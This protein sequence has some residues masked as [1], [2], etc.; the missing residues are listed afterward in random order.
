[1][2]AEN[3]VLAVFFLLTVAGNVNAA[4]FDCEKATSQV[5]KII[6]GDE[7]LSILDEALNV[8]YLKALKRADIQQQTVASQRQWLKKERNACRDAASLK[9][10]YETRIQALS[11]LSSHRDYSR[12]DEDITRSL[13]VTCDYSDYKTVQSQSVSIE[14]TEENKGR[15]AGVKKFKRR[16]DRDEHEKFIVRPG[17]FC[18]CIYPSGTRVRVKVGEGSS[19]PFGECGA[20]PEVFMSLWV[21]ERKIASKVWFAGHCIESPPRSAQYPAVSFKISGGPEGVSVQKCHTARQGESDLTPEDAEVK[22]GAVERLSVC[23]DYSDISKYPKDLVEYPPK[24]TETPKVGDIEMLYGSGAVCEAVLEGLKRHFDDF[25]EQNDRD[26]STTK[27]SSPNWSETSFQLHEEANGCYESVFD[28]NNDGKLDRVFSCRFL[29]HYRQG[30]TLLVQLGRSST[31]LMVDKVRHNIREFSPFSQENYEAGFSMKGR[32]EKDK[33]YFTGRY[34]DFSP[35]FF[36]GT[37]YIAVSSYSEDTKDYVAVLKPLPDGT[38]Q[39]IGLFRRVPE[40]F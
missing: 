36:Q 32:N 12:E 26:Q 8:A 27:L 15:P 10:A 30:S 6:C 28:L 22:K 2:K 38:F 14:Q 13:T 11:E 3:L 31:E 40:N 1:M 20:D 33:V 35:F 24:G 39:K 17:E 19:S 5:E 23:V 25:V 9:N 34:S 29:S 37:T 21:N 7:E 16:K 4:S 18:E